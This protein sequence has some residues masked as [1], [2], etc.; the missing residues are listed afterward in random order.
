MKKQTTTLMYNSALI[1]SLILLLLIFSFILPSALAA[2]VHGNIYGPG[3]EIL[4]NAIVKVNSTPKQV[5]VAKNG[6]YVFEL[7]PGT[8]KIEAYYRNEYSVYAEEIINIQKEGNYIIDIILLEPL[9]EDLF[10][11]DSIMNEIESL[12]IQEPKRLP[13]VGLWIIII[14]IGLVCFGMYIVKKRKKQQTKL[15]S[16]DDVKQKIFEIIKKEKRILQK[17]IRKRIGMSEAKVSL[18]VAELEA[19][20][21][22]KKIKKG[23]GNIIIYK[24][25]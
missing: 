23:R 24:H 9:E 1:F 2:K 4:N 14:V 8:Y 3:L 18:V 22:I 10:I 12:F 5:Y 6:K 21:K 7:P 11:N 16:S 19:E 15:V 25:D 13:N 17:E 20:G